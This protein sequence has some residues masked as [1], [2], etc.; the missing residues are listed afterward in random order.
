MSQLGQ[1]LVGVA[2]SAMVG[3]LGPAPLG[4]SS[5]G[6]GAFMLIFIL[7]MG[8]AM[9]LTPL[10]AKADTEKNTAAIGSILKN[11]GY[12]LLGTGTI[13]FIAV[14]LGTD[15]FYLLN[16][17]AEV[18]EL[19]IPY[20][21]IL[22][23]S[24]LPAVLFLWLKQFTEGLSFTFQAMV[25][26]LAGNI[27]NIILNYVLIYG[28]LGFDAHGLN[29]AGYA[30]LISRIFMFLLFGAFVLWYKGFR[31]YLR[32]LLDWRIDWGLIRKIFAIGFPTGLQHLFEIG[33]FIFAVVM[34]GWIGTNAMAAHQIALSMAAMTFMVASGIGSA[35]TIRVGNQL[36]L[37][38]IRQLRNAVFTSLIIGILIMA[39]FGLCFVLGGRFLASLFID[40]DEVI[41]LAA[42]LLIVA[43]LFQISDGVQVI[44][45]GSLRGLQDVKIPAVYTFLAYWGIGIP[46]AYI[47]GI[48]WDKGAIGIWIGLA[49]GLTASALLLTR[50]FNRK[51]LKLM[52]EING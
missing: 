11:G 12:A 42:K 22:G 27:I 29:G 32:S 13:L 49:A 4:A 36:G 1:M 15:V 8:I 20:V 35:T 41:A 9:A 2:D 6:H 50:R 3:R 40:H 24:F 51:S 45:L 43:A 39:F 21:R 31:E 23:W 17:P 44:S 52:K 26:S 34:M 47:L 46:V 10:I 28:K 16:Q 14:M 7:A 19:T 25:I 38:N 33:A 5:L 30:T 48:L 18:V 37:K